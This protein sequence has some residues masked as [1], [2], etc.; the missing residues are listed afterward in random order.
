MITRNYYRREYW[1]NLSF[2]SYARF[3]GAVFFTFGSMGFIT[4]LWTEGGN[5]AA[6]L[7]FNVVFS[8]CLG[9]AYA[10]GATRNW[11]YI[12]LVLMVH[13]MVPMLIPDALTVVSTDALAQGITKQ[14]LLIDGFG[15]LFMVI[16]GYLFFIIFISGEGTPQARLKTEIDL[17]RKMQDVLVPDINYIDADLEVFGRT[18]SYFEIGGD[19]IDLYQQKKSMVAYTADVSGHGVSASLLMGMFKS[20]IRTLL[21]KELSLAEIINDCNRSLQPL[22]NPKTFLTCAAIKFLPDKKIEFCVAGHLP[23]LHYCQKDHTI[24]YYAQKQIPVAVKADY[25]FITG[26]AEY[27]PG[28]LFLFLSD[29]IS[30]VRDSKGQEYG[31]K[32]IEAIILEQ[33]DQP[34]EVIY[35]SII[36]DVKKFGSQNDDQSLMVIKAKQ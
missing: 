20:A 24:Y 30:E 7:V 2:K 23:V 18:E 16:M 15:I 12:M 28:D 19:L 32:A 29:G 11:K 31:L 8:G 3:L 21:Q 22:K 5:N 36:S 1:K 13:L 27:K 33:H 9:A 34:M 6:V 35:N 10:F 4:D 14:R 25:K 17:A 26:Q